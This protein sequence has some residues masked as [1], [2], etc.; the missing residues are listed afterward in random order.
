MNEYHRHV[1]LINLYLHTKFC[2][3]RKNLMRTDVRTGGQWHWDR[4]LRGVDPMMSIWTKNK[5]HIAQ[6]CISVT[7]HNATDVHYGTNIRW[8]QQMWIL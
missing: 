5:W 8:I 3:N 6:Q 7:G 4:W 1:S 2:S